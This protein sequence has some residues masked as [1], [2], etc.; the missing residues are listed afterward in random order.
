MLGAMPRHDLPLPLDAD[1][2][3]TERILVD[4]GWT[5][6]GAGDWAVAYRSPDG[7]AAARVSPFDPAGP[8]SAAL[9]RE[10]AHTQQVPQLFAHRRLAGGGDLQ[11]LEWLS[12]VPADEAAEFHR[13]LIAREPAFAELADAVRRIHD[14]GLR[15]LPWFAP[16]LD[17]NPDNIMRT[18]DGR[19]VAADL[20]SADGPNLYAAVLENPTLVAARIPESERR[21]ITEI[22]LTNTGRWPRETREAMRVALGRADGRC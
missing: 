7:G 20:F 13:A 21:F 9:Y 12:P 8:Y 18:T 15:E 14:R 5:P 16:K 4:A 6:C 10:A 11:I 19:L 2:R 3:D 17:D 22:P 1:H